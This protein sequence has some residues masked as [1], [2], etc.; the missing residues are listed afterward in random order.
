[1]TITNRRDF[2]ALGAAGTAALALAGCSDETPSKESSSTPGSSAAEVTA[3][4][5]AGSPSA[6]ILADKPLLYIGFQDEADA[7]APKESSGHNRSIKLEG[8]SWWPNDALF[9]PAPD[10][11]GRAWYS[12][13]V[14]HKT[15]ISLPG[16]QS[17]LGDVPTKGVSF[18]MW[19]CQENS[20][21][22]QTFLQVASDG[23]ETGWAFGLTT[24]GGAFALDGAGYKSVP[25]A[26]PKKLLKSWHHVGFSCDKGGKAS[27]YLDGKLLGTG[28]IGEFKGKVKDAFIST[29]NSGGSPLTGSYAHL[30]IFEGVLPEA[31][32]A[33]QY[34]AG[35]APA[36]PAV[37]GVDSWFGGPA[38][39]KQF[40]NCEVFTDEKRFPI[41]EWWMDGFPEQITEEKAYADG[42]VVLDNKV[43]PETMR[44][45]GLWVIRAIEMNKD[46]SG[47]PGAETIGWLPSDEPDMDEKKA[48]DLPAMI[49]KVPANM[50]S[51]A[52]YGIGVTQSVIERYK[53]RPMVNDPGIHQVSSDLYSYC[54]RVKMNEDVA[55]AWGIEPE[56]VR[57]AAA[58][59]IVVD[60][61]RGFLTRPLPV[62]G[63]VAIGHANTVGPDDQGWASVPSAD[64]FEG[65]VWSCLAHGASGIL[66]FPQAFSDGKKA[67]KWDAKA[68]YKAGDTVA[69]PTDAN[70]F[71]FARTAP[72]PGVEPKTVTDDS[73]LGWKPNVHGIREKEF[74]ARGVSDRVAAV[75]KTVQELS[76]VWLSRSTQH[77]FHA[78]LDTRYWA[79]TPDGHAYVLAMQSIQHDKG[80][81][82]MRLPADV[83]V[84][85]LEVVDE[86]RTVKV[87]D[88]VFTDTWANEWEHH[89]YRW[90]L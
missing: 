62:W 68:S 74:Y 12:G 2:L 79:K 7:K 51:Y 38:F 55:N 72:K 56:Q 23:D 63:V 39:Y 27:A 84:T 4:G 8:D 9:W 36:T 16:A 64:E 29:R 31:R 18:S 41:G 89:L 69:D 1:M 57:R 86:K 28:E 85:E 15:S 58:H 48:K 17:W 30:A 61:T 10:A 83:K 24:D 76:Q 65:S 43:A 66:L 67:A 60:R 33:A 11:V 71:W 21:W 37:R 20:N 14:E 40:T 46:M 49:K 70:Q 75:K 13:P 50:L 22:N 35:M 52:N 78:D 54:T 3:A 81:Y 77:R 45:N 42:A 47:T 59:G 6:V 25:V 87:V 82:E 19:I 5:S 53:V 90:K 73:W 80:S 26:L 44:Q 34:A 88:G 32:F